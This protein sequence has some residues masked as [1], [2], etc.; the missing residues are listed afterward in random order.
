MEEKLKEG[1][2]LFINKTGNDDLIG[3]YR[4]TK[5]GEIVDFNELDQED[6]DFMANLPNIKNNLG[7]YYYLVMSYNSEENIFNS[8]IKTLTFHGSYIT[9]F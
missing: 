7:N 6:L 1:Y 2:E 5:N 8:S 3:A 4:L 9:S